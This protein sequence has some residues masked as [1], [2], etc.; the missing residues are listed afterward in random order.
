MVAVGAGLF[1][2]VAN[3]MA[4]SYGLTMAGMELA[5]RDGMFQAM[6][7]T[8]TTGFVSADFEVWT[9]A[10]QG[11]LVAL[12]FVGGMAGSTGGG[13]KAVRVLVLLR[14]TASEIR[15]HLHLERSSWCVSGSVSCGR[16]SS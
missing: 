4:G 2:M 11:L 7:I 6:A 9:P 1:L 15:K 13:I 12:M 10:A 14:H 5:F 3:L 8:T 16:M